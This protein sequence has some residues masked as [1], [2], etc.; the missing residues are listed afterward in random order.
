ML[1]ELMQDLVHLERGEDRLDQH[2]RADRAAAETEPLLREGEHVVPETR[3]QVGLELRQVEV[4][5]AARVEQ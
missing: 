1:A 5:T 4:G 2:R 3:L